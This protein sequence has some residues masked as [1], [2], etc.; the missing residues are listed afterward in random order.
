MY[1]IQHTTCNIQPSVFEW[2]AY[3]VRVIRVWILLLRDSYVLQIRSFRSEDHPYRYK[4]TYEKVHNI[5]PLHRCF[6]CDALLECARPGGFRIANWDPPGRAL[7]K[8]GGLTAYENKDLKWRV[9]SVTAGRSGVLLREPPSLRA[10]LFDT[11]AP[12]LIFIPL[13]ARM[14]LGLE[15]GSYVKSRQGRVKA[16]PTAAS[17]EIRNQSHFLEASRELPRAILNGFG[18]EMGPKM[19]PTWS[20]NG[21]KMAPKRIPDRV[22][23]SELVFEPIFIDFWAVFLWFFDAVLDRRIMWMKNANVQNHPIFTIDF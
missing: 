7:S 14:A 18:N 11:T 22:L 20:Q 19:E 17:A 6:R 1:S 13:L 2:Y 10:P 23:D 5:S 9:T 8:R 3:S 16:T 12:A 15:R 21:P 4:K